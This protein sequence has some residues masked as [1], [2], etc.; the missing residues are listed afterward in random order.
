MFE[1]DQGK[2]LVRAQGAQ[3][4][5]CPSPFRRRRR[6]RLPACCLPALSRDSTVRTSCT[7][8]PSPLGAAGGLLPRVPG[9]AREPGAGGAPAAARGQAGGAAA[10]EDAGAGV[11]GEGGWVWGWSGV[12]GGWGPGAPDSPAL[13]RRSSCREPPSTHTHTHTRP[14]PHRHPTARC[15]RPSTRPRPTSR[16][17][18]R[19]G[20]CAASCRHAQ[21]EA[22]S[23]RAGG[24]GQHTTAPRCPPVCSHPQPHSPALDAAS[25]ATLCLHRCTH[26]SPLHAGADSPTA[27]HFIPPSPAP[28]TRPSPT[29]PRATSPSGPRTR[30]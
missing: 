5:P 1:G 19:T 15:W 29:T 25:P 10:G 30:A 18:C 17:S 11:P 12:H 24:L 26:G 7:F 14:T 23:S 20:C 6:R 8:S 16:P 22:G 9:A 21:W 28:H 13:H 2:A 4:R 3:G 27:R